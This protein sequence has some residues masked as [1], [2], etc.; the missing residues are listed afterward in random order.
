M[1]E[2]I[3]ALSIQLGEFRAEMREFKEAVQRR[4]GNLEGRQR[5]CQANPQ[6]C[7]TARRL[8]EYI[9][10]DTGRGKNLVTYGGFAVSLLSFVIVI[11]KT[12]AVRA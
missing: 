3:N 6:S 4:I 8:E 11:V 1:I 2:S 7:A 10:L 12:F 9:K 5:E